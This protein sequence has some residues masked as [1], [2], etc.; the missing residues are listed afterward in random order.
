VCSCV[1]IV[2][3]GWVE[4]NGPGPA[5][6]RLSETFSPV[7]GRG[8]GDAAPYALEDLR[9][10]W[11]CEFGGIAELL[12]ALDLVLRSPTTPPTGKQACN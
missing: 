10:G 9:T 11:R 8:V 3:G 6:A 7:Q 5:S 2:R 1:R 12:Q 4:G